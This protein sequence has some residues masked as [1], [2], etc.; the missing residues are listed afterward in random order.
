M[1]I[2]RYLLNITKTTKRIQTWYVVRVY[3]EI[4]Y[5]DKFTVFDFTILH[6]I[7]P[8]IQLGGIWKS[9]PPMGPMTFFSS[10]D[11]LTT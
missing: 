7:F 3:P 4:T 9:Y 2:S 6:S 10:K 11:W 5:K 8:V 1:F